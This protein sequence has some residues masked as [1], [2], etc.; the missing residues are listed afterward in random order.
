MNKIAKGLKFYMKVDTVWSKADGS[1]ANS[2]QFNQPFSS[3]FI[4]YKISYKASVVADKITQQWLIRFL[5]V[6][7]GPI[8]F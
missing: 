6:G 5:R 1:S 2:K 4:S 8:G 7:R 3:Y